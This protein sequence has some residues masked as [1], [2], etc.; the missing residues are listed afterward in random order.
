M[1]ITPERNDV[2]ISRLF[3]WGKDVNITDNKGNEVQKVYIRLAT[4]A[5]INI[6]RVYALRKS[7]ELRRKLR[8]QSSEQRMAFIADYEDLES[9][10]LIDIL[11]MT[12][13][14]DI[15]V[16]AVDKVDLPF[17]KEPKEGSTLEEQE[18]YQA[19]VD[20]WPI[21]KETAIKE[22]INKRIESIKSE[23]STFTRERLYKEYELG[24][25]NELCESE[26]NKAYRDMCVSQCSF[27]DP[28]YTSR[29]FMSV[30]ELDNLPPEI[31]QQFIS[32]YSQLELNM[33][34]L[35]K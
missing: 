34:E 33:D 18:N 30:D 35:K 2:N 14:R 3:N 20:S 10:R 15:T 24:I 31:K 28:G 8:D 19:E 1:G 25:I 13:M 17:P 29:V 11:I 22:F 4:D 32:G 27:V 12:S 9:D 6:A 16:E 5:E 23:L 7:K 26:M 21:R